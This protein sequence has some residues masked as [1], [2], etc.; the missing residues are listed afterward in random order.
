MIIKNTSIKGCSRITLLTSTV[1]FI[2][3]F[4]SCRKSDNPGDPTDPG[5]GGDPPTQVSAYFTKAEETHEFSV[6][7]LLTAYGGYRVNTTTNTNITYEWY[8]TSQLYA[9]IAM[10][11]LGHESYLSHMDKTFLWLQ[12]MWDKNSPIGGYFAQANIDGSGAAGD[13]YVDDNSLTG[14]IYLAAYDITTGSRKSDYLSKAKACANWLINSNLWDDFKGGGFWWSTQKTYKPTQT[15]GLALQLFLKLYKITGEQVYKQWAESVNT[16]LNNVMYDAPKGL[17][18]WQYDNSGKKY[19]TF[20][21]YDN[22]IM[23]EAFLLY[24]D[25][26]QDNS[27]ISKAQS[28]GNAM[29]KVLWN[30]TYNLYIFNTDD[31]RTTPAWCGWGSQ[32]MISLYE[33]D[34]NNS[35]LSYAKGNIDA[36]NVILRDAA[37]KGYYQFASL[38]GSG[39]YTNMEGVDAA[40]MQR[41]QALLSSYK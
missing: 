18:I 21:T 15:N 25:A 9:D 36:I 12:N 28:L 27:Y 41:V 8:N 31:I 39:R 5:N 17:Y 4:S 30:S 26:M 33:R 16:W 32:A 11:A 1:I 7:H 19:S 13:K 29:N 3:I 35:W 22:A 2:V 10:V 24:A 38:N 14:V 37:T 34:K 6:N 20:F 40:W 23:I